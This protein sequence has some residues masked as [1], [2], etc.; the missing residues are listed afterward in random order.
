VLIFNYFRDLPSG[1][2]HE[3]KKNNNIIRAFVSTIKKALTEINAL[4][5]QTKL[6]PTFYLFNL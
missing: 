6:K 5:K 2:L 1:A 3:L 4:K